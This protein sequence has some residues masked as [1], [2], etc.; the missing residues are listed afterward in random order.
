[1]PFSWEVPEFEDVAA[2]GKGDS[3]V[4]SAQKAHNQMAL[5]VCGQPGQPFPEIERHKL[6]FSFADEK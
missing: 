3:L 6:I 1:V 5:C 4:S 2:Q